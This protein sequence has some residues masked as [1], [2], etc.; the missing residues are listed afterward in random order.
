[1]ANIVDQHIAA[2]RLQ[3]REVRQ[4]PI[5]CLKGHLTVERVHHSAVLQPSGMTQRLAPEQFGQAGQVG[6]RS[7]ALKECAVEPLSY[8][9]QLWCVMCC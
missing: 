5:Q 6:E 7:D 2:P 1:M 3:H 8:T 4:P 9:I